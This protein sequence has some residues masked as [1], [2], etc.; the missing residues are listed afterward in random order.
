MSQPVASEEVLLALRDATDSFGRLL[1]EADESAEVSTCPGW[2]VRD[3]GEHLGTVHRWAAGILLSGEIHRRVAEVIEQ[4]LPEWYRESAAELLAAI[5]AVAPDTRIPNFTRTNEVAAFWPRRQLHETIM[6]LRDLTLAMHL[7]DVPCSP[8]IA[9]DGIDEMFEVSFRV[10]KARETPPLVREPIRVHA[11]DT[12]DE[13]VLSADTPGELADVQ[14]VCRASISGTA[15]DLYF[16]FWGRLQHET[17]TVEGDAATEFLAGP[18]S[19]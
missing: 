5:A 11:T 13:W 4:P 8:E 16:A 7:P 2:T 14:T 3:L 19:V 9:A 6:H 18:I 10:L 1:A 12:G 15:S 17:L